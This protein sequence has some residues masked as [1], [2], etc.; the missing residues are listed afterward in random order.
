MSKR[1]DQPLAKKVSGVD[2]N[3]LA[4]YVEQ[5]S[6]LQ[7]MD[8]Y[9]ILPRLKILQQM[10]D[11]TLKKQFGEGSAIIRPGDALVWKD[12]DQPFLFVPHFFYVEFAK[13]ADR[14]DKENPAVIARTFDPTSEIAK[15]ARDPNRRFEIYADQEKKKTDQ[16]KFR[17]RY[18]EH[19][20]FPGVIYGDHPL[21]GT[22]VVLSFERGEFGTGKNF[23]SGIKLRRQ[24]VEVN[25]LTKNIAVPLWSQVWAIAVTL[26][27]TDPQWY[28]FSFS[29]PE[30]T[31]I[32]PEEAEEHRSAHLSLKEVYEQNRLRVDGDEEETEDP[33]AVP[34]A[35]DE[36]F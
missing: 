35:K 11:P 7:G 36:K 14:R 2:A 21:T 34:P 25:G 15:C 18:V 9:V 31:L 27:G 17:Y 23:I 29:V 32:Q 33:A 4:Q 1:T 22:P 26:H 5:D 12:G 13:W 6:S 10:S 3:F 20:R 24:A 30:V 28:G 19:L 16:E 8:E